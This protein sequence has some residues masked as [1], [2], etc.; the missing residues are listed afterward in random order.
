MKD[1]AVVGCLSLIAMFVLLTG[2][3]TTRARPLGL[4]MPSFAKEEVIV[5]AKAYTSDES[6]ANLRRDL[7]DRGYQ[8]IEVSIQNNSAKS[9]VF[10]ADSI[11]LRCAD[12]KD[13]AFKVSSRAIP[14]AIAYKIAS[15]LFWP[16]VIPSTIDSIK[17]L[18]AHQLMK[19]DFRAKSIK[20]YDELITPYSTISRI[21]FVKEKD[22]QK[23][24]TVSL[25]DKQSEILTNY[26]CELQEG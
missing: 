12:P 5:K 3:D 18:K 15:T 4:A 21:L 8:P 16:F 25:I 13:V 22:V 11:S 1:K 17:T 10:S 23:E 9:Y 2:W 24:F 7:L 26:R 19:Q 6:K 20:D 14:R